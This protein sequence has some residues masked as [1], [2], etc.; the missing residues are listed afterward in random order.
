M[1]FVFLLTQD[2]QFSVRERWYS[3]KRILCVLLVLILVFSLS[4]QAFAADDVLY[5]RICGRKIPTD[6]L[7]CP[8]C[9]EKVVHVDGED[10][11]K[12]AG[13]A[14]AAAPLASPAPATDVKTALSQSSAPSPTTQNTPAVPGPFHAA[15]AAG[16][17]PTSV[18]VTKSPISETVPFGGSCY[19]IAH[20]DNATSVTW[21]IANNDAS[22]IYAAADAPS[23]IPGLCVSGANSDTL[24]LSGIPA[25]CN[26]A[27]VQACF[28]GEDGPVYSEIAR[29]WTYQPAAQPSRCNWSYWDWVNYY[30]W[31][32]P[33]VYDSCW[34]WDYPYAYD[35][36][37]WYW[38][39]PYEYESCWYWDYP[40]AYDYPWWYWDILWGDWNDLSVTLPDGT[41][42]VPEEPIYE[43]GAPIVVDINHGNSA[44]SAT[45]KVK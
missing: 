3:M 40:Y 9:G 25:W 22:I 21:Y 43:D 39:Y 34:Y 7:V 36:P 30:Y 18:R 5:C 38:G 1:V 6:S 32:Y 37:W 13:S 12:P 20:A 17:S 16:T 28:T 2:V 15:P 4:A 27:Q 45:L 35:Y 11:A 31:D 26:G 23:S 24:Y 14:P 29:I 19:F 42:A 10:A 44:P 8:Y 41:S 33:Y